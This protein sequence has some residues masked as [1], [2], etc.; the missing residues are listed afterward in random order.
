[1][2]TKGMWIRLSDGSITNKAGVLVTDGVEELEDAVLIASAPALLAACREV[3]KCR[4]SGSF[5][6]DGEQG[7]KMMRE[8]VK[9][10]SKRPK[11]VDVDG[12]DMIEGDE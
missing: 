5:G 10:S 4:D 3:L 12:E 2:R 1:M 6:L 8:A 11:V 9:A 7:F